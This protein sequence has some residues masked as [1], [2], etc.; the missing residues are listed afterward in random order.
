[1]T[2]QTLISFP[3]L[4]DRQARDLICDLCRRFYTLGWASG[5]GGGLS[6]RSG[7][8]IYMTPSGVQKDKLNPEDIFVLDVQ[9]NIVKNA[10]GKFSVSTCKPLF[11]HAFQIRNAGAVLQSHSLN[12]MLVSLLY[13]EKFRITGIEMMKGIQ[14]MGVLD[15]LEIPIIENTAHK[16]QL[17]NSMK[18]IIL[19]NPKTY[20][21]LVRG[22]G[23]YIWGKDWTQAKSHAECYEYLFTAAIR[24]RELGLDP[25]KR[26]SPW[27]GSTQKIQ[28][29]PPKN[30]RQK[31]EPNFPL[32]EE[33]QE[34]KRPIDSEKRDAGILV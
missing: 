2:E 16:E 17:A 9:G 27:N 22:H 6:I 25:E 7:E 11:M 12:A 19:A 32:L 28:T 3:V 33:K 10:V 23:V 24:M 13:E 31:K 5:T 1:M 20:A 29:P 34:E 21:V 30:G 8:R 4:G 18:D 15:T 26:F 14:G